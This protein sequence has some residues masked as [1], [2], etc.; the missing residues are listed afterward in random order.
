MRKTWYT[1]G[2]ATAARSSATGA[3]AATAPFGHTDDEEE[4]HAVEHEL[5]VDEP[6]EAEDHRRA[7]VEARRRAVRPA[8]EQPQARAEPEEDETGLE[9]ARSEVPG[10]GQ[11]GEH[12]H[13]GRRE[14]GVGVGVT[15]QA[16]GSEHREHHSADRAGDPGHHR[17]P[18]EPER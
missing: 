9:A 1:A 3:T 15:R 6:A 5:R 7:E 8:G 13:P 12:E 14:Q 2:S 16:R 18:L 17:D 4:R 11:H 10:R